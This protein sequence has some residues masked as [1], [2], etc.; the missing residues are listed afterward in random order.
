MRP[1]SAAYRDEVRP[2]LIDMA[3]RGALIVPMAGTYPLRDAA[4]ALE[5]VGGQHPGGKLALIP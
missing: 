5:R 2:H 4:K 1:E 3:A